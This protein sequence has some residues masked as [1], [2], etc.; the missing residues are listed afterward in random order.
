MGSGADDSDG[1]DSY[2]AWE[3]HFIADLAAHPQGTT[4]EQL[5]DGLPAGVA[6]AWVDAAVAR[7]VLRRQGDRV[8]L[9]AP[10]APRSPDSIEVDLP[11]DP[12]PRHR[13]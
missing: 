11:P 13:H 3:E 7:G 2:R 1:A 9:K 12:R 4:L 5:S 8:S 6:E 10:L